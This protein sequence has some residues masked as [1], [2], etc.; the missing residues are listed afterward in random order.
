MFVN[1]LVPILILG[2]LGLIFGRLAGLRRKEIC[3]QAG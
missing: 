2:V 1:V 3:S